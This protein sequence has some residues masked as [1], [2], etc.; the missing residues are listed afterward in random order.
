MRRL[1]VALAALLALGTPAMALTQLQQ[2]AR[3][4]LRELGF[5]E[6]DVTQLTTS[7][8]AAIRNVANEK[9]VDGQKRGNI[10]SILGGPY[11]LRRLFR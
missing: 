9:G 8:L 11:S 1:G 3:I 4:E 10:R 7:Q 2:M 6:V 5:G